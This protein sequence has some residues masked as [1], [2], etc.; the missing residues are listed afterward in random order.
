MMNAYDTFEMFDLCKDLKVKIY[1]IK[2][3]EH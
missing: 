2:G 3:P 1:E